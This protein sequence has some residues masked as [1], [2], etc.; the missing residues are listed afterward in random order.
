MNE[1]DLRNFLYNNPLLK[2]T[3]RENEEEKDEASKKALDKKEDELD[4]KDMEHETLK[5]K[6]KHHEI[7]A[8]IKL[9]KGE[10]S[11]LANLATELL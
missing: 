1:F 11:E 6:I 10:R 5:D 3:I 8:H 2:A 7:Y 4:K 9:E